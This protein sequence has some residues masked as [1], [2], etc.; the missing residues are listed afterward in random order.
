MLSCLV[1]MK[2]ILL[3]LSVLT[4]VTVLTVPAARAADGD[5][6]VLR[7][8]EINRSMF[9]RFESEYDLL[10]EVE[11]SKAP[12]V[13]TELRNLRY[14]MEALDEDSRRLEALLSEDK[15]AE[16]FLGEIVNKAEHRAAEARQRRQGPEPGTL[17]WDL[18]E[19]ALALVAEKKMEE[20]AQVY[21]EIVMLDPDDDQAYLILGHVRL[22]SGQFSKAEAAFDCAVQIDPANRAQIVPFYEN[23]ILQNPNDDEAHANLGYAHLLLGEMPQAVLSFNDALEI[24]PANE[25]AAAGLQLLQRL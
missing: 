15:K 21:E 8:L 3:P 17:T 19:K 9:S 20:A 25:R 11:T 1:V 13:R 6:T 22:L 12:I 23:R 7:S 24:N 4:V 18:H 5:A 2:K 16:T 14:K 10:K